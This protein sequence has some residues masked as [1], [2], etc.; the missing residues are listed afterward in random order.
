MCLTAISEPRLEAK[1]V[2]SPDNGE[3]KMLE[4]SCSVTGKPAPVI[5]WNLSHHLPQEPGRYLVSHSDQT[6]T[7]ISNFTYVPSRIH[8]ESPVGCVIQHPLLN[9]TLTLPNEALIQGECELGVGEKKK[10]AVSSATG[11]RRGE[12]GSEAVQRRDAEAEERARHF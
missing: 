9:V 7:V 10:K 11:G 6:V 3:Q 8:W 1:L 12:R 2:S 4:I 5:S